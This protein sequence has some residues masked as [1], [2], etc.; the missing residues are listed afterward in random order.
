MSLAMARGLI[1][2]LIAFALILQ[3]VELLKMIQQGAILKIWSKENLERE[4]KINLPL[5]L[6]WVEWFAR[7]ETF[8]YLAWGLILFGAAGFLK[9]SAF[10]FFALFV[11]H[12]ATCIRFRGSLNG[13]SAIAV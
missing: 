3:G 11:V 10:A 7:I 12:V 13:G 6:T 4:F 9:P 8:T 1:A 2:H 5:P